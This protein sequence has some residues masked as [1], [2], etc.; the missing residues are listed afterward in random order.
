MRRVHARPWSRS[1]LRSIRTSEESSMRRLIPAMLLLAAITFGGQSA[2]AASP[3]YKQR[4]I[5]SDD[6]ALIPAEHEDGLLRNAWGL[7]A[8]ATSPW[9]IANNG[10]D[11]S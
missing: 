5:I 4:N 10:S 9:W 3:F 2:S 8:S 6:I 1:S 7:A 11:S